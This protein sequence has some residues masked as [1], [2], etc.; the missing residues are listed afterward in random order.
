MKGRRL[1]TNK[2]FMKHLSSTVLFIVFAVFAVFASSA[3]ANH[4]ANWDGIEQ[5]SCAN[6]YH[7]DG[8]I[9]ETTSWTVGGTGEVVKSYAEYYRKQWLEVARQIVTNPVK[10][11]WKGTIVEEWLNRY[12]A[13]ER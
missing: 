11:N 5:K 8:G 12:L 1:S 6:F 2:K 4:S 10:S 3:L 13:G 7:C 9:I